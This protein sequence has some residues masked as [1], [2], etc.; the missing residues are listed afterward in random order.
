MDGR[1]IYYVSTLR[2]DDNNDGLSE[3]TPFRSLRKVAGQKREPGDM[4]LLE[5]GSVFQEE[6]LHIYE[7][8]TREH[9]VVVDAYG[10]GEMPVIAAE[11]S[12]LWYQNYGAPLDSPAHVWKGYVSSAVL[13]YDAEYITVRNIEGD[14]R[15][16][17]C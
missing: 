8:G 15:C 13:L 10:Q 1:K 9:P 12:G 4:I 16:G 5:R 6:Y 11:G 3:E 2:G 14:F 7:G 17:L